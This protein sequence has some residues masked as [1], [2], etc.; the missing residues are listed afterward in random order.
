MT[1]LM[2]SLNKSNKKQLKKALEIQLVQKPLVVGTKKLIL[3][4]E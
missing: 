1:T 3:S 4:L 2:I